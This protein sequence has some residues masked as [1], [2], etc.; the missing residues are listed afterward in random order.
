MNIVKVIGWLTEEEG[1]E[2]FKEVFSLEELAYAGWTGERLKREE[3][4]EGQ[5]YRFTVH[6]AGGKKPLV[7]PKRLCFEI[8]PEKGEPFHLAR[9]RTWKFIHELGIGPRR[10]P[11][12]AAK[13]AAKN[14]K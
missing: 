11:R 14:A 1:I 3:V 5:L 2:L 8:C 9:F 13:N 10:S 6:Q 4:L 7:F 12:L